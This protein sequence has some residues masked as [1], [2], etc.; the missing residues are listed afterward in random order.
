MGNVVHFVP[1]ANLSAAAN[2][3]EFI[4]MARED[5]TA[6]EDEG[7]WDGDKWG[8]RRRGIV[9]STKTEVTDSCRFTPMTEPFKQFAKAYVRYGWSH[10]PVKY[11]GTVLQGLRCVEA[12][13]LAT[14]GRSDVGDLTGAAMD[15][16]ASKCREFYNAK[17]V[18]YAAGRQIEAIFDFL[19]EKSL[20]PLVLPWKSPFRKP[21]ILTEDVGEA[22]QQ[23][24]ESKLPSSRAMLKVADYFAEADNAD[25][26]YFSS[27]LV[28][29]MATPSRISEVLRLPVDCIHWEPDDAGQTQMYLRWQA[30]KGRGAMKKWVIPA[31]HEVVNEALRRLTEVGQP[32]QVAAKFA[33]DHPGQFMHHS[34]CLRAQEGIDERP[35]TP[36]QFCAAI[37]IRYP[38]GKPR[39][40]KRL[41]HEVFLDKKIKVLVEQGRTS[42]KDLAGHVLREYGGPYWPYVDVDRTVLAWDALCLHRV[43]EFHKDFSPKQFSWRIPTTGEVNRR[44]GIQT[45][46]SPFYGGEKEW[47]GGN[48]LKLTTHQLRHWISTMAE[49]AGMDDYTLAQW[50]G[51]ARVADNMHYDHRTPLERLQGARELLAVP[52]KP[53]LERIRQREPVTYRQ[54]GVDRLGTAKATLYGMCVHDFAMA[55]CQKQREC[56]TCKEHVCIKGDH[57]KLERIRLLEAQTKMLLERAQVAH[58]E[59]DF[60]ADRWV[61]S[62][63]WKLAHVQAMR[64]AL[65]HADVPT[66]SILRIPDGHDPSP[67]R[68]ALMDIDLMER[69]PVEAVSGI[70]IATT[71]GLEKC[72]KS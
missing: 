35:L 1:R 12:A 66:G 21:A 38:L 8:Q 43:N 72:Q 32:A 61:D 48:S 14:S 2:L 46:S 6:F 18:Q 29:L 19:R 37:D 45:S 64:I 44:L 69:P 49:R 52:N 71:R 53:M 27:V 20:V 11:V 33:L 51:R 67:V 24:R 55:P 63:K 41:W 62:H 68:R 25:S 3:A 36:E 7:A 22:G 16:C 15:V 58:Q 56:M 59:G 40:G 10:K 17:Q 42:Y 65:E 39:A 54:L 5:L 31:M 28:L 50:A 13:L 26:R 47:D 70:G 4:R 23:Y 60:G 57:G 9:F 30:A 34:G